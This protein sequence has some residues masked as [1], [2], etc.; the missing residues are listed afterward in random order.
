MKTCSKCKLDFDLS[1]Y[2]KKNNKGDLRS[3]CKACRKLY[4]KQAY[5]RRKQKKT[6]KEIN[7]NENNDQEN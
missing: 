2:D 6:N 4:N 3:E 1:N 5:L 7:T